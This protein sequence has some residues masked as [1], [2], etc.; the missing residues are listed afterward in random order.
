[1]VSLTNAIKYFKEL[2][3]I[4]HNLFQKVEERMLSNSFMRTELPNNTKP[5]KNSIKK[6]KKIQTIIRHE[7]RC[8]LSLTK[9]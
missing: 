1:M 8:K 5:D 9:D 4:L 3:T 2:T 6:K 7:H